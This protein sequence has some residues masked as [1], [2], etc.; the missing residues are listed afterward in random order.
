MLTIG[1]FNVVPSG[2]CV[3]FY[4]N[5]YKDGF[6]GYGQAISKY[7]KRTILYS[8]GGLCLDGGIPE[9]SISAED[10]DKVRVFYEG[11]NYACSTSIRYSAYRLQTIKAVSLCASLQK[12]KC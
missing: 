1:K 8:D 5:R 10:M 4:D 9:W 3:I 12:L 7:Y 2:D 11:N 6:T